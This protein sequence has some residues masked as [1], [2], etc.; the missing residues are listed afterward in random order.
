[1][2]SARTGSTAPF[3]VIDTRHV[4]EGDAVEQ[5]AHVEDGIDRHAGHADVAAHARMV[6]VVAA[7]GGEIEGHRQALLPGGDV[8]AIEGVGVLRRRE[9]G[10]LADG[11]RLGDVHGR[12]GPAQVGRDA[13]IA[14]EEVETG[15]VG[16]RVDAASPR[17]LR[18]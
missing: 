9:P 13:G 18:A 4:G 10:V 16:G 12:V 6:A 15:G 14:V 3:M 2:Y 5:R 7:V 17:C 1:M 11:P 8:A